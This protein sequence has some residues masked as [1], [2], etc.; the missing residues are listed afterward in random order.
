MK[1]EQQQP[2]YMSPTA[3]AKILGICPRLVSQLCHNG[4]IE[5][6]RVR[7]ARLVTLAELR[8]WLR[9]RTEARRVIAEAEEIASKIEFQKNPNR[10]EGGR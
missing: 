3:A 4:E 10:S 6:A 8:R 2:E 7:S 9:S 5:Y 1:E